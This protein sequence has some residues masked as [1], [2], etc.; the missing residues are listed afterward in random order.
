MPLHTDNDDQHHQHHKSPPTSLLLL[1]LLHAAAAAAAAAALL[2]VFC[3]ICPLW[4]FVAGFGGG[5]WCK[6]GVQCSLKHQVRVRA[7]KEAVDPKFSVELAEVVGT[8]FSA[9]STLNFPKLYFKLGLALTS[10]RVREG[11]KGLALTLTSS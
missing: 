3:G 2:L 5:V 8:N 7:S 9:A 11:S 10:N 6:L 1:L 4:W